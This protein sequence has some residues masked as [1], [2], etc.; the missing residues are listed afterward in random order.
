M[1]FFPQSVGWERRSVKRHQLLCEPAAGVGGPISWPWV[2]G[3]GRCTFWPP[4]LYLHTAGLASCWA[5]DSTMWLLEKLHPLLPLVPQPLL[6]L[7][8]FLLS[9]YF[10]LSLSGPVSRD[11]LL[12]ATEWTED[13]GVSR[14]YQAVVAWGEEVSGWLAPPPQGESVWYSL[15]CT[16]LELLWHKSSVGPSV[17]VEIERAETDDWRCGESEVPNQVLK[18]KN[19]TSVS[20]NLSIHPK[21]KVHPLRQKEKYCLWHHKGHSSPLCFHYLLL[22]VWKVWQNIFSQEAVNT[23]L[24]MLFLFSPGCDE[25][26]ET[27]PLDS[28]MKKYNLAL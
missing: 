12:A 17:V 23:V 15:F 13:R 6:S 10:T 26:C 14:Q 11:V 3:D 1:Y 28:E 21:E 8:P 2:T 24:N 18:T 4:G 22:N 27:E 19:I 9:S 5:A 20:N 16:S 7:F 25:S